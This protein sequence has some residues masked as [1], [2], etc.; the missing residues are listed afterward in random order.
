MNTIFRLMSVCVVVLGA[1]CQSSTVPAPSP[2][3]LL[4]RVPA[5]FKPDLDSYVILVKNDER[6]ITAEHHL[7]FDGIGP[8][9]I[10][11]QEVIVWKVAPGIHAVS[12]GPRQG[13]RALRMEVFE[14]NRVV[15]EVDGNGG[16][17]IRSFANDWDSLARNV[18][19]AGL[20]DMSNRAPPEPLRPRR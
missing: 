1:G 8:I 7:T 18:R 16:V 4:A 20:H 3:S 19:L 5:L 10:A 14:G 17:Y 9:L 15:F 6:E 12:H 2:H 11:K 13:E